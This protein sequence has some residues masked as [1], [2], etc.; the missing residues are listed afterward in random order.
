MLNFLKNLNNNLNLFSA[1]A[2]KLKSLVVWLKKRKL[3]TI[4]LI[5]V[6][7]SLSFFGYKKF[8][9]HNLNDRYE[10]GQ[11]IRQDITKTISASGKIKSQTQVDLKFQTSGQLAW[12]GVK[13][14]DYVR[15][16]QALASLDLRQL[17]K[18]LEKYLLDYSKERNDWDEDK[19]ITYRDTVI[20]DTLKRLIEK[21]QFDLQKAVLD[22]ELQDI[23]LK[24][25][26]L[27][28][29]ISGIVTHIDIPVAGINITPAT[30]VFTVADPDQLV[31]ETI[32][33]E[34]DIGQLTVGQTAQLVLDAYPNETI[35]LTLDSIDFTSTLD[36][37]GSTVFL[38]KFNLLNTPEKKFKLG[39]NG[40]VTI[41]VAQKSAVLAI[42]LTAVIEDDQTTVQMINN[43]QI[44]SQPITLGI[45]NDEFVEVTSGLTENQTIIIGQ[46]AKKSFE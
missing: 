25:A 34:V 9:P 26:T 29:P 19:L 46:K 45:T 3:F 44:I 2:K 17:Q 35:N 37:S 33:D 28:T 4:F 42:P 39:M 21:N 20:T 38:V 31:F 41:T 8:G 43:K 5:I 15:K 27:I 11:V 24:Y 13:E 23:S 30:A 10:F 18:T 7:F 1:L 14:G 16:W 12:I 22:V 36:T 40:E 6:I 32:I